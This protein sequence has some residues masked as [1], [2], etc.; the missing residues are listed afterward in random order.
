MCRITYVS[1]KI[2]TFRIYGLTIVRPEAVDY[3][4]K[5]L[6]NVWDLLCSL[7]RPNKLERKA[8]PNLDIL[9]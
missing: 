4:Y 5:S 2:E 6:G 1:E 7:K 8:P 9:W 3:V